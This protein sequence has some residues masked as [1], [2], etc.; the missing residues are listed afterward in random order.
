[1]SDINSEISP[2]VDTLIDTFV[3]SHIR[4]SYPALVQFIRAYLDFLETQNQSA[5]FQNTLPEQRFIETQQEQFLKRIEK[6]IGLFVPR[7]Y[8]ADPKLFYNK[9][10]E[11]WQSRGSPESIKTFFRIFFDE[12][13]E[14]SYPNERLLI[15]S[16]SVWFQE[17]FITIESQGGFTAAMDE[18]EVYRLFKGEE[19][20]VDAS[21]FEEI[22]PGLFRVYS[23]KVLFENVNVGDE[24]VIRNKNTGDLIC[25]GEVVLSPTDVS[26]SVKGNSW[27]PGQVVRFPGTIRDTLIRVD[28][29][30]D[31][32]GINDLSIV[33]Y[34]YEHA[35][36]PTLIVSPFPVRPTGTGFNIT[37]EPLPGG[38]TLFSLLISSENV[39]ISDS[40]EGLLPG[41]YFLEEYVDNILYVGNEAFTTTS[42]V[43][44]NVQDEGSFS[45]QTS[46]ITLEEWLES[47]ATIGM[48]F[49]PRAK[50]EGE[51]RDL[52][53]I[54]SEDFT[55]IQDNFFYQTY[56]YE[57]NSVV[58]PADY[59]YLVPEFNVAG[60]KPFFN[61]ERSVTFDTFVVDVSF[62]LPF[63]EIDFIDF[64]D[65]ID[66]LVV[67]SVTKQRLDV[68]EVFEKIFNNLNKKLVDA[69]T[70]T[71]TQILS[72]TKVPSDNI[73]TTEEITQR[74][75][76]KN[77]KGDYFAE[78]YTEPQEIYTVTIT[79]TALQDFDFKDVV[80]YLSDGSSIVD[81][82]FKNLTKPQNDTV[83][84]SDNQIFI[85]NKALTDNSDINDELTERNV[86]KTLIAGDYF[87][88]SYVISS[89]IYTV[90][91]THTTLEDSAEVSLNGS[92]VAVT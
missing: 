63:I 55:R 13:V 74:S 87:S 30:D 53:S 65:A 85:S 42:S 73:S 79:R 84:L 64:I 22:V 54:I 7:R 10:S 56:S 67:K 66:P 71:D 60:Q 61:Y 59:R 6:E 48:S 82:P 40:V 4:E 14:I 12:P 69:V 1:M 47:R 46:D 19:N 75:I 70:S 36:S 37:E 38:G 18:I 89:E 41:D 45:Y 44:E 90:T 31:D 52:S 2:H 78:A 26:V 11:L 5:Y 27:N 8:E 72:L 9:I 81:E 92:L 28:S 33:E 49:A 20:F 34:G 88:D 43:V 35:S 23:E 83:T 80:K 29:V 51:W 86:E 62:E 77:F 3:P 16:N 24:Y 39:G 15:P 57:L 76:E 50:L 25:I 58:D 21:R 68:A 17:S 91:T 32:G